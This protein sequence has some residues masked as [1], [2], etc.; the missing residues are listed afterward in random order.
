[1]YYHDFVKEKLKFLNNSEV[2]LRILACLSKHPLSLA[3]FK[4]MSFVSYSSIS[5]NVHKL[6][7]EGY[8]EKISRNNFQ[9]TN[10]GRIYLIS[11]MEFHD[12]INTVN[13]FS[14]FWLDHDVDALSVKYLK[15]ISDLEGSKLIKSGPADIYRTC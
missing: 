3:D 7:L 10:M 12:T 1:M 5:T 15:K 11:L 4:K 13:N 9:L 2:R 6:C 14:E 8:V